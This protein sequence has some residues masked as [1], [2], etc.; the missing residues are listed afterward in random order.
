MAYNPTWKAAENGLPGN[1]EATN[2]AAQ[3]DQ[4]LAVHGVTPV[5]QGN[6]IVAPGALTSTYGTAFFW[7]QN[8]GGGSTLDVYDVDWPFTL[9]GGSTAIGHV[10]VALAPVGNGA[11]LEVTLYP[12]SGGFPNLSSPLS[13]AVVP[14][15]QIANLGA[16][17][18]LP[19]AG[20][21]ATPANNTLQTSPYTN[22]PWGTT[23]SSAAGLLTSTSTASYGQYLLMFG[24]T[25]SST[26]NSTPYVYTIQLS[27]TGPAAAMPQ[28]S[29]PQG[30]LGAGVA[31]SVDTV[32]VAG[33]YTG[34]SFVNTVYT[35]SWDSNTGVISAWSA[36]ATLP[37]GLD[38]AAVEIWNDSTVYVIG[39]NTASG[40]GSPVSTVSYASISNGQ[41]Q[42]WQTGPALP[43]ALFA[44]G[45][46]IIG[47]TLIVIGG[48]TSGTSPGLTSVYWANIAAD[49]SLGTWQTGP[50]LPVGVGGIENSTFA[51]D[52]GV[53]IMGGNSVNGTPPTFTRAMQSLTVTADGLGAWQ[54]QLINGN[55]GNLPTGGFSNGDGTYTMISLGL[56][57]AGFSNTQTLNTVP[58]IPV[59]LP[60][61]GLTGGGTYHLLFHQIGGDANNYVKLGEVL[62]SS[63]N[64]QYGARYTGPPWTVRGGLAILANIYDQTTGGQPICTW[65]DPG[66]SNS[67]SIN[68]AA[69]TSTMVYDYRGRLLGVCE[70]TQL[71]QDPL[72]SNPTFT[73]G[74]SPWTASGGTFTQSNAQTHGGFSFSG[75]LTP[76]GVSSQ[77]AAFSESVPATGGQWY[78]ANAW[79]YSPVGYAQ[80]WLAI[81]FIDAQHNQI[82]YYYWQPALPANTWTNVTRIAQAPAGTAYA[83]VSVAEQGTPPGSALLYVSNCFLT[84]SDPTTLASVAAVTYPTG[85]AW[86]PSGVSQLN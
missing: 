13:S 10:Q 3:I 78:T 61:S 70:G 20:A 76:D 79:Y 18:G 83:N 22:A 64:W 30:L 19:S 33:G 66:G 37:A 56:T 14:A 44:A 9:P 81:N 50:S 11:D 26:G 55:S 86:P 77:A 39:G 25:D 67:T 41:I 21:L 2:H 29:L 32:V 8:V 45:S 82:T 49:G 58:L 24:G 47:N 23:S 34:S 63:S 35:A 27:A 1:L 57:A 31:A 80:A 28:P 12:D 7:V 15:S 74:I 75:L 65:E 4:F 43:T 53:F 62:C 48:H 17:G 84:P 68:R 73:S 85:T 40:A 38:L 5:Y 60:A 59:P 51:T 54:Q 52:S 71:P 46:A 6:L 16:S 42:S 72:N 69:R 36:Q